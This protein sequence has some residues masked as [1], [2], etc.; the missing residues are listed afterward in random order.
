MYYRRAGA[1]L[2]SVTTSVCASVCGSVLKNGP[3]NLR[4]GIVPISER[5]YLLVLALH[6][7]L[8]A[9]YYH[10]RVFNY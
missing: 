6:I 1:V 8:F 9:K 10:P 4:Q 2:S 3:I 7:F 5:I